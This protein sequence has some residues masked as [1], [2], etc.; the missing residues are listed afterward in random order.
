[1]L[2]ER[3]KLPDDRP[4]TIWVEVWAG[5]VMY[6]VALYI[7]NAGVPWHA[8]AC[9]LCLIADN[10]TSTAGYSAVQYRSIPGAISLAA[11]IST[12]VMGLFGNMPIVVAPGLSAI[13]IQP[14]AA[15]FGAATA[16]AAA[17]LIGL[18]TLVFAIFS[19]RIKL[20][21]SIPEDYRLGVA[22]GKGGVIALLAL[23]TTGMVSPVAVNFVSDFSYVTILSICGLIIIILFQARRMVILSFV[24]EIVVITTASLIIR[25]TNGETIIGQKQAAIIDLGSIAG[26]PSF[27]VF[28]NTANSFMIFRFVLTTS[29]HTI[30]DMVATVTAVILMCVVRSDL[31][32]DKQTFTSVLSES[33]KCYHIFM[34]IALCQVFVNPFLG[35]SPVC[36]RG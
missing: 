19:K 36:S 22:A 2:K 29:L 23:K 6:F 1:M 10:T 31:G 11:G 24:A 15:T 13:A 12:L 4:Q 8:G 26:W 30:I 18:L 27:D 34:C 33:T 7:L 20:I 21:S 16:R 3:Y 35:V 5:I 28:G 9:P 14:L 32:Y 17:L 25:A